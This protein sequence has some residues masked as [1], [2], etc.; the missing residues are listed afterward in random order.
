MCSLCCVILTYREFFFL[1][2]HMMN[3]YILYASGDLQHKRCAQSRAEAFG[4]INEN[5][6]GLI[7]ILKGMQ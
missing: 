6:L 7:S 5:T 4:E 1:N 3:V 2:T